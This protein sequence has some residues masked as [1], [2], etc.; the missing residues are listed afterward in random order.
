MKPC[1][2]LVALSAALSA[3]TWIEGDVVNAVTGAPLAGAYVNTTGARPASIPVSDAAGHFRVA[4]PASGR[5]D[6]T[7]SRTG[8]LMNRAVLVSTRPGSKPPPSIR[9]P[10][11]PQAVIT[12]K[13]EDE[14]GFPVSGATVAALHYRFLDGVRQLSVV[15]N[16]ESTDDLGE[17]RVA[18]LPAGNYYLWV[19]PLSANTWDARY[20]PEYYPGAIQVGQAVQLEVQPGQ[21]RSGIDFHVVRRAGTA[22]SGRVVLPA[23]TKLT[24][25]QALELV[26]S[27]L[28]MYTIYSRWIDRTD[29]TFQF[30]HVPPG[31]YTL[32]SPPGNSK[33]SPGELRGEISVEVGNA[34]L[35]GTNLPLYPVRPVDFAG[36]VSFF[37]TTKPGPMT[38]GLRDNFGNVLTTRS[39][40]DGSFV[41]KGV[42]PGHYSVS[43]SRVRENNETLIP[44]RIISAMLGEKEVYPQGFPITGGPMEPLRITQASE[45]ATVS[46]KVENAAGKPQLVMV[47]LVSVPGG[48]RTSADTGL[49]GRFSAGVVTLGEQRIYAT[50]DPESLQGPAYLRAHQGDFPP[51]HLL[52]SCT[53]EITLKLGR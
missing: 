24:D 51:L 30:P 8:F 23:G 16:W 37:G 31:S 49:D 27:N 9:I 34:D 38:V 21:E 45:V 43:T 22:V 17:Y 29:G 12:G 18:R 39:N 13:V 5:L 47:V 52:E 6:L 42:T 53:P 50:T 20:L 26:S 15:A 7:V 36:S 46:G 2:L 48:I 41:L 1:L 19:M 25:V 14:D 32:R 11:T 35:P 40:D 3:Q 28:R 44:D 4:A 10:L 33:P